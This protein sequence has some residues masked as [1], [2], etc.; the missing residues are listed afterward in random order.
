MRRI[1]LLICF[2]ISIYIG[3]NVISEDAETDE[4]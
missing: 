3:I 2:I 4:A 1:I